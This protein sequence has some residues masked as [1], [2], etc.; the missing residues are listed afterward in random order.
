MLKLRAAANN[1]IVVMLKEIAS[2]YLQKNV[3]RSAAAL[4]YSLT[5][6]VFPFLIVVSAI[7]GRLDLHESALF[8]A[9]GD[10]IPLAALSVISEFL[11]Y[12]S[13]NRTTLMLTVGIMALL[14]SSS[15][16]FRN[17]INIT[18]EIQ[19]EM[20]FKG[21]WKGVVSFVFS[22]VFIAV[23]YA[24]GLMIL[25]GGWLVRLLEI[26]IGIGDVTAAW[27]WIRFVILF[28]LLFGIIFAMYIISAP[29]ETKTTHRLPGALV[30]SVVFVVTSIIYSRMISM[31]IRYALVYGSLASIIIMMVWLYTCGIIL[32]MGNVFNISLRNMRDNYPKKRS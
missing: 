20:R 28:L 2:T 14:T 10:V 25:S 21:I 19:G 11:S 16:A 30:A 13:G 23:I 22:I 9:L 8:T 15:A 7:L 32:I 18:G 12:V 29:K 4:S 17:F 3:G 27:T 31:S 6:S 24:S 26:Y 1:R 5:L